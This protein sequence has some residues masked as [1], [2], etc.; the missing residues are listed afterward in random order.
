MK[1]ILIKAGAKAEV[2]ELQGDKIDYL[3][4]KELLEIDS[5]VTCVERKIG[6][7]YYDLWLDD[8]GLLKPEKD[9]IVTGF[10]Q[11]GGQELLV[12]NMLILKHDEEGNSVGLTDEDLENVFKPYHMI[13]MDEFREYE[14]KDTNQDEIFRGYFDG[15]TCTIKAHSN[16]L[17]Y[18]L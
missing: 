6:N 14:G 9:R 3:K 8:E 13:N 5:P 4:M 7:E 1:F 11:F 10:L 15:G 18:R 12:G 16:W 17:L 2:V